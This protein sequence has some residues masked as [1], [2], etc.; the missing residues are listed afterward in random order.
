MVKHQKKIKLVKDKKTN[1][2]YLKIDKIKY[3]IQGA[4]SDKYI[5]KHL[6]KYVDLFK[7]LLLKQKRKRKTRI[8]SKNV[9][10][11]VY[12]SS[13][14]GSAVLDNSLNNV[15][16]SEINNAIK[17]LDQVQKRALPVITSAPIPKIT[18]TNIPRIT[19]TQIPIPPPLPPPIKNK[20]LPDIDIN[21]PLKIT[22][23]ESKSLKSE[24]TPTK[25]EKTPS[26]LNPPVYKSPEQIDVKIGKES[27]RDQNLKK[28]YIKLNQD[29]TTA[30]EKNK[31][32]E[33]TLE[34]YDKIN[35]ELNESNKEYLKLRTDGNKKQVEEINKKIKE[36]NE[37]RAKLERDK[38]KVIHQKLQYEKTSKERDN[39]KV[40]VFLKNLTK[41]E[42]EPFLEDQNFD[43]NEIRG[44]NNNIP[45]AE[46]EKVILSSKKFSKQILDFEKYIKDKNIDEADK[47]KIRKKFC[48]L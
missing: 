31:M 43:L 45:R 1:I 42:L 16:I 18:N 34:G 40:Q 12:P 13:I 39:L 37:L 10:K 26:K 35:K 29:Y 3:R 33:K 4:A 21:S 30:T 41:T 14:S 11:K 38:E 24:K 23:S 44:E 32:Y 20:T 8:Y 2:R 9:P 48:K 15:K 27:G 25:S 7:K 36:N 5:W 28:A 22:A 6:N 47:L 46:I 17:T 19:G